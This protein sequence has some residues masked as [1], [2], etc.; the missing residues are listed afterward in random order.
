MLSN[1]IFPKVNELTWYDKILIGLS[2][3]GILVSLYVYA[4]TCSIQTNLDNNLLELAFFIIKTLDYVV[5]LMVF[6]GLILQKERFWQF[7]QLLGLV[8][9][10][11]ATIVSLLSL[12]PCKPGLDPLIN[13]ILCPKYAILSWLNI[14]WFGFIGLVNYWMPYVLRSKIS[15]K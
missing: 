3:V 14:L 12:L 1:R 4:C 7:Q 8:I 15:K 10:C 6:L 13:S 2:A 5:I 9:F 11:C